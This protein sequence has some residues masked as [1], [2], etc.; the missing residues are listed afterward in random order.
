MF[1]HTPT[2]ISPHSQLFDFITDSLAGFLEE[3]GLAEADLPLGFT[4]SYP[5]D[6]QSL[7]CAKLLRWTK[8]VSASGVEGNDVVTILEQSIKKHGVSK[9]L[10]RLGA[11]V[12]QKIKVRIV[13]LVN[14]TVGT[15]VA[16]AFETGACD[17]GVIIG[18]VIV[19]S[20]AIIVLIA[21]GTNASYMEKTKKITKLDNFAE[22][23]EHDE[24]SLVDV[25]SY[26]YANEQMV[27]DTEWGG[28]GDRGE[29]DYILTNYDKL[30]DARSVHPGVQMFV[31]CFVLIL[32]VHILIINRFDKIVAG[33]YMGETVRLVLC[34]LIENGTLHPTSPP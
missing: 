34:D 25:K 31:A 11:I 27:I 4:F 5:C 28:F 19:C 24:V 30:I 22:P 13:A 16:T 17:L 2:F 33:M 20:R 26:K 10:I 8:G 14:D 32:N 6:Q 1:I 15:Q 3:K 29:A 12:L 7:R 21:T 9:T 18:A 23:Y